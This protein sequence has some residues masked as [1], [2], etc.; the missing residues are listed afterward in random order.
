ETRGDYLMSNRT[1][2]SPC[3]CVKRAPAMQSIR[4]A[5]HL[6]PHARPGGKRVGVYKT[7]ARNAIHL[8][9]QGAS[10]VASVWLC[11]KRARAMQSIRLGA[12]WRDGYVSGPSS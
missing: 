12:L 3:V 6:A 9:G 8:A 11:V 10:E 7:C 1:G 4:N 2:R 5:T